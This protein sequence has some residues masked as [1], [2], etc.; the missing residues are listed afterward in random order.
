MSPRVLI[1]ATIGLAPIFANDVFAS[2]GCSREEAMKAESEAATRNSWP[3]LF[4]SFEKYAKCDDAA[5][6][7]GYS[8]SVGVLLS[9]H[10]DMFSEFRALSKDHSKFRKFV[11]RHVDQTIPEATLDAIAEN[12]RQRCPSGAS[13]E[14]DCILD[15]VKRVASD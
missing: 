11:I 10:W 2:S 1:L 6:G 4:H 14:C 7:E 15:A 13:K 3:E 12:A 9:E 8:N 5:I